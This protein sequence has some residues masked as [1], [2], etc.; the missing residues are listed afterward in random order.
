MERLTMRAHRCRCSFEREV[1]G[2]RLWCPPCR[3]ANRDLP[4]A[5]P[6]SF[7][8][9][10]EYVASFEALLLEEA[11]EAVR[12]EWG[13]KAGAGRA[14]EA[15]VLECVSASG[16]TR[17]IRTLPAVPSRLRLS[18]KPRGRSGH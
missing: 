9:V 10:P 4:E 12:E 2:G 5:L 8:S 7:G 14:Y 17:L 18:W 3:A 15:E 1:V 11:R 6:G 13:M 16:C